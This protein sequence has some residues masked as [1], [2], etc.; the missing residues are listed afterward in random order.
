[1]VYAF[2]T[3]FVFREE[4][5]YWYVHRSK[6][7]KWVENPALYSSKAMFL[8]RK[9][10]FFRYL[11]TK[12]QKDFVVRCFRFIQEVHFHG[13]SGLEITWQH[14]WLIAS[15]YVKMTWGMGYRPVRHFKRIFVFPKRYFN[16]ITRNYHL[17]EANP[18]G[19]L[20]FSWEDF[21]T[22]VQFNDDSRH[23]GV[24]EFTHM[25]CLEA[26]K[27][28]KPNRFDRLYTTKFKRWARRKE[29]LEGLKN[30]GLYREYGF[31]NS[32]EL[33]AV[34]ME[35]YFENAEEMKKRTP[36]FYQLICAMLQMDILKIQ[37]EHLLAKKNNIAV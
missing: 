29:F 12:D 3:V 25:L 31:T 9:V 37:N 26:E 24:H 32:Y 13:R 11:N 19:V 21:L 30:S 17:G 16:R 22:G 33:L 28:R 15:T 27:Q 10:S 4:L 2:I 35:V 5:Y 8:A 34:S 7:K 20:V 18:M 36:R 6:H 1:M 14:K 23:L